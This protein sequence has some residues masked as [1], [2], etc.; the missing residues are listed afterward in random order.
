MITYQP[1]EIPGT[2]IIILQVR[3]KD[4]FIT[5]DAKTQMGGTLTAEAAKSGKKM[6]V[7]FEPLP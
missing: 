5:E 4:T 7:S 1:T 2:N 3:L 6:F